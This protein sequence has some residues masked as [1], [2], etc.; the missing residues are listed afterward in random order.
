MMEES[1]RSFSPI[2][3]GVFEADL[4]AAELH[5]EGVKV[6][7][8]EQ[9]FQVLAVLLEHAGQLVTREELQH[10]VWATDTFVDF[11]RGLNK[12]INRLRD[13][14]G[15]SAEDPSFIETLPRRGYRFIAQVSR[16]IDSLAVL[17]FENLSG[18]PNQEYWAD[19]MTDELI[20]RIARIS[21][22]R[23]ISR[24]SIVRFK[25]SR[26][27]LPEMAKQLGVDAV[28]QGSVVLSDR[29]VRVRVQMIHGSTDRLFWSETYE[30]ELGDVLTLQGQIAQAIAGQVRARLAPEEQT[31][32][33]RARPAKPDAY[34]AYLKGRFF[35]NKR[36]EADLNRAIE[37]FKQAL[38]LDPTYPSAHAG[39][40]DSYEVLGILGLFPPSDVFPKAKAAA[41][42]A[43]ELDETLAETHTT[44]AHLLM[45][46]DWDWRG[47]EQ[48]FKRALELNANYS[49][50]HLWYGNLLTVLRRFEDA[51]VELQV[52]R[53]L[54][55]LSLPINT[56]AGFVY[57]RARQY[58][59]AVEA[60]RR[61]IELDP[62]NPFG[63]WIL[64]R[65][66]DAQ[67]ELGESLSE[68]EKAATLSGD[69]LP[70]TAHLGY[71]YARI[72]DA[73]GAHRVISELIELSKRRYVSPYAVAVIYTGLGE[74]DSAFEWLEKAYAD[75][76]AR[77]SELADPPFD[78]LRSDP[79]FR[80]LVLRVGLPS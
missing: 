69:R 76:T 8:Q 23:V 48:E 51:I 32:L 12:A 1:Q 65:V 35:W 26:V 77:L 54:D 73:V 67:N 66:W 79:R 9:P 49:I 56:F 41:E 62:N 53:D 36:T 29:R 47:A 24:A 15:D 70:F 43:L 50:A 33:A 52:A 31:R 17:P 4:H 22:L 20:T 14:L 74:K 60:C 75:R 27:P 34:E 58:D 44:L 42:T 13:A 59:R 80:D 16:R 18:D 55:P 5:R 57:M 71:A 63:H 78:N 28:T 21:G 7:L 61:A 30:R 40:A 72:G 45:I 11:E 38:A 46:Y 10:R 6:K 25:A 2:R 3:F 68:S 39:L 37:Y 19:G 64:A